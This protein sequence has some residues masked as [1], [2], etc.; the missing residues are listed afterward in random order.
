LLQP[1]VGFYTDRRPTPYSLV[2]GMG[3]T[4]VGLLLLAGA[5]TYAVVLGAAALMGIGSAGFPPESSRV[6]RVAGGGPAG[7]A[8]SGVPVGAPP[9]S[10]VGPLLAAFFIVPF[11]QASIAWCSLL[12]PA[13]MIILWRIGGWHRA[14]RAA[15]SAVTAVPSRQPPVTNRRIASAIAI[16]CALL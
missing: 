13:A 8:P 12:A 11:G 6:A 14:R 9:G 7:V 1:L 16:L 15:A 2:V 4:L 10:S 5:P 3:F